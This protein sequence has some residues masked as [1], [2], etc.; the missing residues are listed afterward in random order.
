MDTALLVPWEAVRAAAAA[1]EAPGIPG[2]A[3]G[4]A[5]HEHVPAGA[6]GQG[7]GG[8][9]ECSCDVTARRTLEISIFDPIEIP[10]GFHDAEPCHFADFCSS[11]VPLLRPRCL[12]STAPS[13][14]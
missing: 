6:G 8:G 12:P 5:E 4:A 9:R 13:S 14:T 2:R 7:R 10:S 1:T 3:R 11:P